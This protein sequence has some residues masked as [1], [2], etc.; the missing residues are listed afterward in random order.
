MER[1]GR[2]RR[3]S[4]TTGCCGGGPAATSPPPVSIR[5]RRWTSAARRAARSRSWRPSTGRLLG[6]AG[7]GQAP[8]SVHPGAVYLHQG[9]S[10]SSTRWI[11][12]MAI[13]FVHADDPGYTTFARELTDIAVT[14]PGERT[15]YGA[16]TLGLVPVS[17]T[18]TVIGYLRRRLSGEVI[19]F[20]E[21]D[22]PTR[23]LPTVA[24]MCTITP[25]ALRQQRN[26]SCCASRDR[27]TPPNTPRSACCRWW[28]AATAATSAGCRQRSVPTDCRRSSSTTAIPAVPASPTAA[29]G[30]SRRGG[31]DGCGDRGLRMPAWLPV[32]RAVA[33]MRQRQRSA[34]QGGCDR[35]A[36]HG[37]DRA[38]VTTDPSAVESQLG[39]HA[40]A[41]PIGGETTLRSAS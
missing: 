15:T 21:L 25:E 37:A 12:R 36:A 33:E 29:S 41:N 1:R 38:G 20:V 19:D 23:T 2:W 16:V 17:V 40:T 6:S 4:S 30:R 31:G 28:P 35:G 18:N 14:G 13:A 9:E 27:C 24:V 22:M 10:M 7:V 26:R 34:R 32:V 8:A 39:H 11:S 3:T 5:I